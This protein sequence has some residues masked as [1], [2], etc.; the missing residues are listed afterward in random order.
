MSV[1][2]DDDD[3][4]PHGALAPSLTRLSR[5]CIEHLN[6]VYKAF[7]TRM[8]SLLYKTQGPFTPSASTSVYVRRI[9]TVRVSRGGLSSW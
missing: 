5:C 4:G 8:Q 7:Y 3:D 1:T 6:Q 2:V 9:F